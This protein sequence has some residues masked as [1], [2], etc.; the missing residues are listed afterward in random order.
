MAN[1]LPVSTREPEGPGAAGSAGGAGPGRRRA[2]PAH[3]SSTIIGEAPRTGACGSTTRWPP[4]A[5]PMP[6]EVLALLLTDLGSRNGTRVNGEPVEAAHQLQHG[7]TI[8]IAS[9]PLRFEDPN[10]TVPVARDALRPAH[11]PVWV[12]GDGGR[13]TLSASRWS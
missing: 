9:V 12:D 10:A 6:Q 8:L 13:P 1:S 5:T 3:R 2:L 11:L 7:D 4:P